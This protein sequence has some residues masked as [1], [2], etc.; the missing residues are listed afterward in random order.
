MV[1]SLLLNITNNIRSKIQL[2]KNLDPAYLDLYLHSCEVLNEIENKVECIH[3][4]FEVLEC[5]KKK[6]SCIVVVNKSSLVSLNHGID[7]DSQVV[8]NQ[9][10]QENNSCL[11]NLN[12]GIDIDSQVVL[13]QNT[14]ENN[15]CLVNL[16]HGKVSEIAA[17]QYDTNTKICRGCGETAVKSAFGKIIKY[18]TII[19]CTECK[20]WYHKDKPKNENC[21]N[22]A[23]N[24]SKEKTL[25][26]KCKQCITKKKAKDDETKDISQS[27]GTECNKCKKPHDNDELSIKCI[28]CNMKFHKKCVQVRK[29][30]AKAK[31]E[32]WK[33]DDCDTSL[34]SKIKRVTRNALH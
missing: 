11:V 3:K 9:N 15:S 8:L 32:K 4:I 24:I 1:Q 16:N 27:T 29:N 31:E 23:M 19:E 2:N 6:S 34:V 30:F 18:S 7:I 33:C 14:Q 10:I 5:Y 25:S 21:A 20:D 12:H 17:D 22:V 26:W 13:N 28:G